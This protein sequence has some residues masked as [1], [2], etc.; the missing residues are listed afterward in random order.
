MAEAWEGWYC[1]KCK[2][3]VAEQEVMFSYLGLRRPV[4]GPRCPKC[5]AVFVPEVMGQKLRGIE[6]QIEDK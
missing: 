1:F 4:K 3:P 6:E 2:E 5:S